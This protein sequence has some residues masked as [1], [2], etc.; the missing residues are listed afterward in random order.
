MSHIHMSIQNIQTN[1]ELLEDF[2][3]NRIEEREREK[4]KQ[5][6]IEKEKELEKEAKKFA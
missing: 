3:G 2:L 4:E 5:A 6:H 1:L